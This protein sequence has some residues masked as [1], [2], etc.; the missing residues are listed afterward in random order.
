M[1]LN[2]DPARKVF[3]PLRRGPTTRARGADAMF[4][5]IRFPGSG[6]LPEH[7][8][9][10]P[11]SRPATWTLPWILAGALA[12]GLPGATAGAEEDGF[13]SLFNGKDL[14]GWTGNTHGYVVE[15]GAIVCRPGCVRCFPPAIRHW[16]LPESL[17]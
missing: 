11:G 7:M 6:T 13:V 17:P 2:C 14:D 1:I 4:C 3:R 5:W 16:P 10:H 9:I 12:A 8:N 15:D